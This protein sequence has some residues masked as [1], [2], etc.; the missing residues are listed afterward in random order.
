MKAG[1]SK[2][3]VNLENIDGNDRGRGRGGIHRTSES[4][5]FHI[6]SDRGAETRHLLPPVIICYRWHVSTDAHA[7]QLVCG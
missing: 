4:Y 3:R 1:R 7:N 2:E 6:G 5:L